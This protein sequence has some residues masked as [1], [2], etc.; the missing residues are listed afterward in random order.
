MLDYF[1]CPEGGSFSSGM[2][3]RLGSALSEGAKQADKIVGVGVDMLTDGYI[4]G[5][6]GALKSVG[7]FFLGE[8]KEAAANDEKGLLQKA[9]EGILETG[10][11]GIDKMSN[12]GINSQSMFRSALKTLHDSDNNQNVSHNIIGS[13]KG[14]GCWN[15]G[16]TNMMD[17]AS[18]MLGGDQKIAEMLKK[19]GESIKSGVSSLI[20]D[21]ASKVGDWVRKKVGLA[22]KIGYLDFFECNDCAQ[23]CSKMSYEEMQ[24]SAMCKKCA[25]KN[26]ANKPKII[27]TSGKLNAITGVLETKP[28]P[29]KYLLK[30]KAVSEPTVQSNIQN[31]D[32]TY[33]VAE[34]DG[35]NL[36]AQKRNEPMY[37][38]STADKFAISGGNLNRGGNQAGLSI[39]PGANYEVGGIARNPNMG[40]VHN[41]INTVI[42]NDAAK[43]STRTSFFKPNINTI[44]GVMNKA[45]K[46]VNKVMRMPMNIKSRRVLRVGR[47]RRRL[48][49]GPIGELV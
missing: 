23:Q 49:R 30:R 12:D 35:F 4:G 48:R 27:E 17:F 44:N 42:N 7:N 22:P 34:Q 26:C 31:R 11:Y 15:R 29:F 1:L 6:W 3:H 2:G 36:E 14:A 33:Y 41:A 47:E 19:T 25:A 45:V 10:R 21:G 37:M 16:M 28:N 38:Q 18:Y 13:M 40:I 43:D 5:A 20:K 46:N 8:S 32:N 9:A 39:G 24:N